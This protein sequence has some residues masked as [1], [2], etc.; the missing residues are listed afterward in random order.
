M[1]IGVIFYKIMK[2]NEKSLAERLFMSFIVVVIIKAI[3]NKLRG[4]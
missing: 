1:F 2:N 3:F 4:T